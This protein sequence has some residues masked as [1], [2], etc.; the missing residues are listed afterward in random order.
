[1]LDT[2][3]PSDPVDFFIF[4]GDDEPL[5]FFTGDVVGRI[6]LPGTTKLL[7]ILSS[8]WLKNFLKF[9]FLKRTRLAQ[10]YWFSHS[11]TFTIFEKKSYLILFFSL[12]ILKFEFFFL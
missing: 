7:V 5:N 6:F 1:M 2:P 12:V 4:A 8:S 11:S 3:C 9:Y 10:F